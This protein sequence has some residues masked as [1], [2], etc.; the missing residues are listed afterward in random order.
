MAVDYVI[1]LSSIPILPVIDLTVERHRVG[2]LVDSGSQV[3]AV[4][5]EFLRDLNK[6]NLNILTLPTKCVTIL[7]AFGKKLL[8]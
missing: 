2:G 4:S 5:D 8:L 1:L 6:N 7:D 3:T